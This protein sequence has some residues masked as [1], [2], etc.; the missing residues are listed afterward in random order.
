M[1]RTRRRSSGVL[2]GE[3]RQGLG[4]AERG[5]TAVGA[6]SA[7]GSASTRS[8]RRRRWRRRAQGRR[9]HGGRC[10]RCGRARQW[11]CASWP[12]GQRQPCRGGH[13]TRWGDRGGRRCRWHNRHTLRTQLKHRDIRRT[14]AGGGRQRRQ[15]RRAIGPSC[16]AC[17]RRHGRRVHAAQLWRCRSH[18][19][20]RCVCRRTRWRQHG[21]RSLHGRGICDSKPFWV[22]ERLLVLDCQTSGCCLIGRNTGGRGRGRGWDRGWGRHRGKGGQALPRTAHGRW[23]RQA[24]RRREVLRRTGRR[25]HRRWHGGLCLCLCWRR[26]QIQGRFRQGRGAGRARG[27]GRVRASRSRILW[28]C[29]RVGVLHW[30]G[31][32]WWHANGRKGALRQGGVAR[33]TGQWG[34]A[35]GHPGHAGQGRADRLGR[36]ADAGRRRHSARHPGQRG[37]GCSGDTRHTRQGAWGGGCRTPHIHTHEHH[38]QP[39]QTHKSRT[40]HAT[41][42]KQWQKGESSHELKKKNKSTA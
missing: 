12:A 29:I 34:T 37:A 22:V 2:R 10:R 17:L 24:L 14:G 25:Q 13:S 9:R 8:R 23:W 5:S 15:V 36:V 26:C 1:S 35:A 3:S 20:Q 27:Q 28:I 32:H 41:N 30:P 7:S 33:T 6:A 21:W 19:G 16:R 31:W 18:A 11:E 40:C 38:P 39:T 42:V 4:H